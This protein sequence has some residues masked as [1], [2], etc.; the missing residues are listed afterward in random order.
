[1]IFEHISFFEISMALLF[2][3]LAERVLLSYAPEEMVG[4]NGWLLRSS[5]AD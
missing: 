5:D 4:P 2:I 3:G 1:M